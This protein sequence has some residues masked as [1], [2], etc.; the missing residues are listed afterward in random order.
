MIY[1]FIF[2]SENKKD[3]SITFMVRLFILILLGLGLGFKNIF[4]YETPFI[5]G[6]VFTQN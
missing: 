2:F 3:V 1:F 5:Y 6:H 4:L